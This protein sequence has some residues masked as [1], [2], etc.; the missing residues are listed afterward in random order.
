MSTAD[1]EYVL[2]LRWAADDP[3]ELADLTGYLRVLAA[4][5]TVTVVDGSPA[6]VFAAHAAAWRDL[7]VRHLPPDE[8]LD[9]ATG[10]VNGV[11]TALR[12]PGPERAVVADDDVRWPLATLWEAVALLDRAEVVRPQNVFDPA[13]WHA[14]WDTGRSLLNRALAADWPGTLAVRRSALAAAGGYDG[15]ALFEN[16]ELVRT[17]QAHGGRE[18][19]VPGLYVPRRPPTARHFRG[20]RVRQAY[21]S[22][23]QPGR[24]AVEVALLPAAALALARGRPGALLAGALGTVGLAEAGR[25]RAGGAAVFPPDAALWAPVWLAERAVCAWLAVGAR[26]RGGVPYRGRRILLA[27]HSARHLRRRSPADALWPGVGLGGR[28]EAGDLV[29]PVAERL[30]R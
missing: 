28:P 9:F 22:F 10:K 6:P 30:A 19:P 8:D 1:V 20:Q 29:R 17:V 7:P 16:L 12:R 23:A 25:R 2:P 24:L 27:A 18:L 14:R 26:L 5:V 21:D 3:A 11:W 15:D 4:E 13:P